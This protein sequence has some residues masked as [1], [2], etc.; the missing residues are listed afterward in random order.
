MTEQR[1]TAFLKWLND[2][3]AYTVTYDELDEGRRLIESI[4]R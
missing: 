4:L 1:V 2:T 3:P